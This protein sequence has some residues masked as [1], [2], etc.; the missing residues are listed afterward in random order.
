MVR[1]KEFTKGINMYNI[2]S[3]LDDVT[4]F[5]FQLSQ[6]YPN[7]FRERTTIK[8]CIAYKTKV[9]LKVYDEEHK[10]IETLV[11]EEKEPGTYEIEFSTCHSREGGNLITVKRG[12]EDN[13]YYYRLEAGDY[14]CEKK[15]EII[16]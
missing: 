14:K 16:K 1:Q 10:E 5:T 9:K 6:N 13:T 4:P 15:M 12:P 11:D 7:P 8:Y 2:N 3:L